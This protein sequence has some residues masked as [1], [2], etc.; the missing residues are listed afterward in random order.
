MGGVQPATAADRR[1]VQRRA[2]EPPGR[3]SAGEV[4]IIQD[5]WTAP[6]EGQKRSYGIGGNSYVSVV[7]FGPRVRARTLLA[8]GQSND[9]TSPHYLDQAE[10]YSH[11]E[12]KPAWT[13]LEAV[14]ANAVRAYRPGETA[15]SR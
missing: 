12:F 10:L 11:G 1:R 5:F 2:P 7:E 9:P 4:G 8:F 3:R 13:T 14:R 15:S 6:Q